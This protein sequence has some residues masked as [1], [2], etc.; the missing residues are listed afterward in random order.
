MWIRTIYGEAR[1]EARLYTDGTPALVLMGRDGQPVATVTVRLPSAARDLEPGELLVKT[2]SEN[3]PLVAPLLSSGL[4][5]DTGK[6][7]PTGYTWAA[8]WKPKGAALE[9]IKRRV[10]HFARRGR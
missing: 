6:R 7:V 2:W 8:V 4:F 3:E 5:E 1:I 9:I 10:P